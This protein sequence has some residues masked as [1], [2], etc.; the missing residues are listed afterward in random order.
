MTPALQAL[1]AI[2]VPVIGLASAVAVGMLTR[3]QARESRLVA[4]LRA[5]VAILKAERDEAQVSLRLA[6][7]YAHVLRKAIA[8]G[9]EP[10][11]PP[12]PE[13]LTT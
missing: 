5:D 2:A 1:L 9:S 13:G 7:D 4:D 8:E 12:W 6:L 3:A 10:P 11:P